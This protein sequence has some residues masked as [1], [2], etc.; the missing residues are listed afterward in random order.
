M[1]NPL[2]PRESEPTNN[3]AKSRRKQTEI[4]EIECPG[5]DNGGKDSNWISQRTVHLLRA[6]KASDL[7]DSLSSSSI[8]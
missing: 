2:L 5:A 6:Q 4:E 1:A 7:F 3:E 8:L